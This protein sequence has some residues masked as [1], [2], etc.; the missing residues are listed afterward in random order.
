MKGVFSVTSL[1][2]SSWWIGSNKI[3]KNVFVKQR[4]VMHELWY[5]FEEGHRARTPDQTNIFLVTYIVSWHYWIRLM[6]KWPK[7]ILLCYHSSSFYCTSETIIRTTKTKAC[8]A[9][10]EVSMALNFFHYFSWQAA[11][12]SSNWILFG[13]QPWG[14]IQ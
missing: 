7:L 14:Y 11:H 2:F 3:V 6:L 5:R 8:S 12:W 9:R 4:R 10:K 13:R 1:C